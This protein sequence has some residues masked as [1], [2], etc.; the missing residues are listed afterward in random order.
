VRFSESRENYSRQHSADDVFEGVDFDYLAKNARIDAGVA[1]ELSLAPPAPDVMGQRGP[2]LGRGESGYDADMQWQA[3]PGATGY[4]IVW[5]EAWTPDWQ[6]ERYVGDVTEAVLPNVSI[7]DYVFGVAA[8][9][10]D[11][12]ESMVSPYVRPPRR[13]DQVRQSGSSGR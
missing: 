13:M 9:G 4:R 1:A 8:L 12:H 10:P 2:M 7:D 3:S 5:R 6:H 11:G